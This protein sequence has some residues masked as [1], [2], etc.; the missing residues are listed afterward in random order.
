[1]FIQSVREVWIVCYFRN[2]L[3]NNKGKPEN[4][5]IT[6][7]QAVFSISCL[8]IIMKYRSRTDITAIILQAAIT[9]N[10]KTRIMYKAYLSSA[11]V[12][13]YMKFL[14]ENELIKYDKLTR[15]YKTTAKGIEFLHSYEKIF[16]L[17]S[18]NNA[19]NKAVMI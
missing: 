11:I 18:D 4:F 7:V 5:T 15:H 1:M 19:T 6:F 10:T 14:E 12:T 13:Q 8:S 17:L 9:G 2:F 3:N 16:R